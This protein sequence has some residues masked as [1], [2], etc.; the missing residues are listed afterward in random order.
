MQIATTFFNNEKYYYD[1]FIR[2]YSKIW[3]ATNFVFFVGSLTDVD[4]NV[5]CGGVSFKQTVNNNITTY[6]YKSGVNTPD[7]WHNLK[8]VFFSILEQ[9]HQT[10]PSL[11][12]D[13]D[14]LIYVK[15]LNSVI[16]GREFKTHFYEYV[17]KT[18]FSLD[19]PTTWSVCPWYYREQSLGNT[20]KVNHDNC[21]WFSLLTPHRGGHMGGGN[22][23]CCNGD[24]SDIAS[25]DNI[26]FHV[27]VFSKEHYIESKHWLQTHPNGIEISDSCRRSGV[28]DSTFEDYYHTCKFKTI[29]VDLSNLLK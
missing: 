13:C 26:C 17:P 14:E 20:T 4:A 28:L 5:T 23:Y 10:L 6:T 7:Q 24:V 25:Y 16:S 2:W 3:N 12:V 22:N 21:K 27:G 18:E 29:D 9:Q 15:D 8:Q 1:I 19:S 11:W